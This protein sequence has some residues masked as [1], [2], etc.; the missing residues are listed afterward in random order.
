[1]TCATSEESGP[2]AVVVAL[3]QLCSG[4]EVGENL[5][6]CEALARRAAAAGAQ[7]VAFPETLSFVGPPSRRFEAVEALD[8]PI[9]ARFAALARELGV[10][11]LLGSLLEPAAAPGRCYNTSALLGEEGEVLGVYR[12]IHLFDAEL[13]GG[14][15]LRESDTF[16]PGGE[17]VVARWRGWSLGMSVCYDLRFPELYRALARRGAQVLLVP[18]AFTTPTGRDH[19]EVLLRAR[20]IEN[21]CYVLAPNQWGRPV[22]GRD[23]YG[24]S[25]AI[26]PWGTVLAQVPDGE[27]FALAQLDPAR[28]EAVRRRMPCLAHARLLHPISPS[29]RL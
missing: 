11:L 12:K 26:D 20:A 5:A 27:G 14:G 21:Q 6:R 19:W 4:P 29:S 23:S 3:A 25:L 16:D 7:L 28:V 2:E 9:V 8:G 13:P 18:S 10:A 1:M 22:E 24:R 17:L 15:S